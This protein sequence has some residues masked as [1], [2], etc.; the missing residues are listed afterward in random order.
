MALPRWCVAVRDARVA[1]EQPRQSSSVR[2]GGRAPIQSVR[3]VVR[4]RTCARCVALRKHIAHASARA[5]AAA[6]GRGAR[7]AGRARC[8]IHCGCKR[9][10]KANGAEA[11]DAARPH[12]PIAAS[13][14]PRMRA[15]HV[16]AAAAAGVFG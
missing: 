15:W 9:I 7:A 12:A 5:N 2:A 10:E 1:L 6:C 13:Y 8:F 3:N 11:P 14:R 16:H 4:A